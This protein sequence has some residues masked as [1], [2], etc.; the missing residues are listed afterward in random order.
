MHRGDPGRSTVL[1]ARGRE[2]GPR[3]RARSTTRQRA[4]LRSHRDL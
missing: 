4:L 1:R 3:S 2:V